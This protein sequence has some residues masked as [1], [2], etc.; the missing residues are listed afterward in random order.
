MAA[1]AKPKSS[2]SPKRPPVTQIKPGT[3]YA[4]G[5]FDSTECCSCGHVDVHEWKLERGRLF[6]RVEMDE[7]ETRR[8]RRELG[9][10]IV[11]DPRQPRRARKK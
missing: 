3:W 4:L 8:V 9:I 7:A 5:S 11:R 6:F 1:R 10:K 2:R